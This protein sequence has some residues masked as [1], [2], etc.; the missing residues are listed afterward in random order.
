MT[1][2]EMEKKHR[3]ALPQ[4][5]ARRCLRLNLFRSLAASAKVDRNSRFCRKTGKRGTFS[6][7]RSTVFPIKYRSTSLAAPLPSR[8]AQT[9]RLWPRRAS[10]AANTP[11]RFVRKS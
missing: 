10:P 5:L 4:T 2:K 6:P 7:Y 8:M 11:S 3:R 9:T 1:L